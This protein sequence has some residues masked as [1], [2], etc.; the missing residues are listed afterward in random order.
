[1]CHPSLCLY[2]SMYPPVILDQLFTNHFIMLLLAYV[3]FNSKHCCNSY[4]FTIMWTAKPKAKILATDVNKW[5]NETMCVTECSFH[6][7]WL[8]WSDYLILPYTHKRWSCKRNI[9]FGKSCTF[10]SGTT[11]NFKIYKMPFSW[12]DLREVDRTLY[13]VKY[14]IKLGVKTNKETNQS[15]E[16]CLDKKKYFDSVSKRKHGQYQ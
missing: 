13:E 5:V 16:K 12:K 14:H 2:S 3:D 6:P 4:C 9:H 7:P 11:I 1:M 8:V 10:Y 15:I